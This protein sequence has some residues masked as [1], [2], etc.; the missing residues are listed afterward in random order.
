MKHDYELYL[1]RHGLA[2]DR[3][4][5]GPCP[6]AD[7]H[8]AVE[9]LDVRT[10][11][12]RRSVPT[13]CK[14]LA[15]RT[16]ST[17]RQ[18][19]R[20]ARNFCRQKDHRGGVQNHGAAVRRGGTHHLDVADH[21]GAALLE[22][23]ANR[24]GVTLDLRRHS[25]WLLPLQVARRRL[26]VRSLVLRSGSTSSCE[27]FR[28]SPTLRLPSLSLPICTRHQSF[29]RVTERRAHVTNLTFFAFVQNNTEP[30]FVASASPTS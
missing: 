17:W 19:L 22:F 10:I 29:Y 3:Q 23:A 27:S 7:H 13:R 15:R 16:I 1:I 4:P 6:L 28:H 18:H 9:H 14:T 11:T 24:S 20:V 12:T 8:G 2:E 30:G 21:R 5:A 25:L 26:A